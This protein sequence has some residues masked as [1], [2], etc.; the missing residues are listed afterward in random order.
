MSNTATKEFFD[1][2]DWPQ[3]RAQKLTLLE[4]VEEYPLLDGLVNFIDHI[5]DH[6]VD[7]LGVPEEE[8]FLFD[9]EDES[10]EKGD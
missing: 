5:Q 8:V 6:A 10:E 7:A 2:V 9:T 1:H 4:L 3:L